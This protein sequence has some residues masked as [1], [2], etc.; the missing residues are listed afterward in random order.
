MTFDS[1]TKGKKITDVILRRRPEVVQ[2]QQSKMAA[3]A[4]AVRAEVLKR[5]ESQ[6][7]AVGTDV[8]VPAEYKITYSAVVDSVTI[9][10]TPGA[11]AVRIDPEMW[12]RLRLYEYGSVSLGIRP[13]QAWRGVIHQIK[14]AMAQI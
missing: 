5:I 13:H 9:I 11:Y 12:R 8:T 7:S 3:R 14:K 1:G 4:Y 10:E 6:L 2:A